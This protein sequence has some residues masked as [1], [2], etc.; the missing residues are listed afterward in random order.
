[1][2]YLSLP[3]NIIFFFHLLS[4]ATEINE[5]LHDIQIF[6][7]ASVWCSQYIHTYLLNHL[8]QPILIFSVNFSMLS[9]SCVNISLHGVSAMWCA[10]YM[11]MLT[12]RWTGVSSE[13][14][15]MWMSAHKK[16]DFVKTLF[17]FAVDSGGWEI[18]ELIANQ[19]PRNDKCAQ[20]NTADLQWFS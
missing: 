12:R 9:W 5:V 3:I 4:W 18:F 7:I 17:I 11:L 2:K 15:G 20:W 6:Q 8:F 14:A 1:M 10:D 16:T 13:L 19:L